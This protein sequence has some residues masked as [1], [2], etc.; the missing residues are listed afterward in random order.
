[1]APED[2]PADDVPVDKESWEAW[3][4]EQG[5]GEIPESSYLG[6]SEASGL[7]FRDEPGA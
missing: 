2:N 4:A 7:N 5:L 6:D 3:L 1:M